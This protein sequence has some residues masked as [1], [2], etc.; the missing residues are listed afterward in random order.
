MGKKKKLN[1]NI[2]LQK[3]YTIKKI[4]KMINVDI[5]FEAYYTFH[6]MN[7][8]V[9][10]FNR[11]I[12]IYNKF[13]NMLSVKS[14][15]E[16]DKD[17]TNVPFWNKKI[18]KFST[19]L[20]LPH[21]YL[22]TN[23]KNN[24][25]VNTWFKSEFLKPINEVFCLQEI[26]HIP[27]NEI[28]EFIKVRKITLYPTKIQA[29]AL[30]KMFGTYRYF[31]N[32]TIN[33]INNYDKN[34]RTS[35][36][37]INHKDDTSKILINVPKDKNI[38]D[39]YYLR[40]LLKINMPDWMSEIKFPSHQIDEAINEAVIRFK[41]NLNKINKT[42][43]KFCMTNKTKK[44][45]KQTINIE[46]LAINKNGIFKNFKYKGN[47][48]FRD[49]KMNDSIK[50]YNYCGSSITYHRILKQFTLNLNYKTKTIEN[51]LNKVC[52]IDPGICNFLTIYS[53][54]KVAKIGI[55]CK[56]KLYKVCKEIDIIDS[57]INSKNFYIKNKKT[58]EKEI[59]T[60]N[61]K[62]RINLIKAKH[63]KIKKLKN[64]K[65][66]LHNQAINYLCT[67]YSKII[68]PPFEIQKIAG[69]LFSKTARLLYNLSYY[70]F[71]EK[72]IIKGR[73]TNCMIDVRPE[74]Y[75]SK[76]CTKCGNLKYDLK[77]SDRIYN[78]N[79]CGLKI[80]RDYAAARNI[81]LRNQ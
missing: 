4:F 58:G 27:K 47:A 45:L 38:Y 76:T 5:N 8:L 14:F 11:K 64:L 25:P 35:H 32:R 6:K 16:I 55:N 3:L 73:E 46:K 56:E 26:N 12:N 23:D 42:G 20:F 69:K 70:E 54:S 22:L 10:D 43:Q 44:N 81:I 66:E 24:F 21:E 75:T 9:Q 33:V 77:L 57:R 67:N 36:Y 63:H 28:N 60:V 29:E 71:K 1:K 30:R 49:L 15:I 78:C 40:S 72:L 68:L 74:Y 48:I 31:Y 50:K 41:T 18:E 2:P 39:F 53:D 7:K 61:N 59:K 62:R 19:G 17:L 13:H 34:K 80:D 51:K 79:K 65:N 52:S 37:N